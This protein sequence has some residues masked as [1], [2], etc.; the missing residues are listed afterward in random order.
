MK[1]PYYI[2]VKGRGY[3]APSK[4]MKELGFRVVSCGK[5]GPTAQA[6]AAALYAKWK[7]GSKPKPVVAGKAGYVYFLVQEDRV[8]IGFTTRPGQRFATLQNGSAV[9]PDAILT[10]PGTRWDEKRLHNRFAPFRMEGEWFRLVHPVSRMMA[11]CLLFRGV[12][13]AVREP[14]REQESNRSGQAPVQFRL[15]DPLSA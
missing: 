3:F 8:K 13:A 2:V 5:D 11:R 1:V 9:K 10:V 6:K 15:A 4:R 12:E 7:S 14:D